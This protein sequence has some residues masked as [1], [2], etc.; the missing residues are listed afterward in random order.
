MVSI[1]R[2][3]SRTSRREIVPIPKTIDEMLERGFKQKEDAVCRGCGAD[4]T[5]WETPRG[6][7]L[8]MNRGTAVAHFT[9]C[10]NAEDFRSRASGEFIS[11]KKV[12]SGNCGGCGEP[13]VARVQIGKAY[14]FLCRSHANQLFVKLK[15]ASDK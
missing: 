9:T 6:K 8:P 4:M 11:V 1:T 2:S 12:R 5:W 15:G 7:N 14:D 13:A 10:P 3:K